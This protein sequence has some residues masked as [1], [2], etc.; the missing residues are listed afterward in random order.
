MAAGSE[1]VVMVK[2]AML[3]AMLRP[4]LLAWLAC[5]SVTCTVTETGLPVFVV[6][7]PE[8]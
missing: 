3:M 1:V 6:G 4:E 2:V 7:V 8:S 5:E